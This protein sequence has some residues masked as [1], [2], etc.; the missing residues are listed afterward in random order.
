[1]FKTIFKE[2]GLRGFYKGYSITLISTPLFLSLFFTIYNY[3]KPLIKEKYNSITIMNL[4]ILA[5][6]TS[7]LICNVFT[8]PLWVIRTRL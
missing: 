4:N 7:G 6:V 8:N 5:S 3:L 2:E 1:M